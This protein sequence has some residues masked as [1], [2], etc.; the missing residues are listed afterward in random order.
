M[1]FSIY[2]NNVCSYS[3]YNYVSTFERERPKGFTYHNPPSH[4]QTYRHTN[5][6]NWMR[7]RDPV[8]LGQCVEHLLWYKFVT[9]YLLLWSGNNVETLL[10]WEATTN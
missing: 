8:E 4:I 1:V 7:A 9:K 10:K 6:H 3:Y 5:T 2:S